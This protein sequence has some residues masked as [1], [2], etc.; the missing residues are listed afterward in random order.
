MNVEIVDASDRLPAEP[1]LSLLLMSASPRPHDEKVRIGAAFRDSEDRVFWVALV[2]GRPAGGCGVEASSADVAT[3]RYLAVVREFRG[4]GL[5]RRLVETAIA[6][7]DRPVVEAE[8]D[9]DARVFYA[10]CGFDVQSLGEKYP[11]TVRY[12][13][14]YIKRTTA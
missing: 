2:D 3:I 4:R 12:L 5:G 14:R 10:R 9:D 13:C 7:T 11:G 1:Y 6:R 8:T